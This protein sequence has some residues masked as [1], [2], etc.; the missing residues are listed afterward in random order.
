MYK[1]LYH[2]CCCYHNDGLEKLLTKLHTRSNKHI[3]ITLRQLQDTR[4]RK[5][6]SYFTKKTN[7][8]QKQGRTEST[9][10]SETE[11]KRRNTE[12]ARTKINFRFFL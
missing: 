6:Q 10:K 2:I 1:K 8:S 7:W 9:I 12:N 5:I 3:D 11:K 4:T